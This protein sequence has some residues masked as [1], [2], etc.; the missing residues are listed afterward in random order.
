VRKIPDGSDTFDRSPVSTA[1]TD[2]IKRSA[3]SPIVLGAFALACDFDAGLFE[4]AGIFFA[5]AD[6]RSSIPAKRTIYLG[7]IRELNF[8]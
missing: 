7:R 6:L 2:A 4:K 5:N 3:P 8:P 1:D